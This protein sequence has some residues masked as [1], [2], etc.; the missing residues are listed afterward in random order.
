MY[1]IAATLID[2]VLVSTV[3]KKPGQWLKP[4][5][6]SPQVIEKECCKLLTYV[7]LLGSYLPS[8]HHPVTLP[9]LDSLPQSLKCL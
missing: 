1:K 4:H 5:H 6:T 9:I 3:F 7:L 8:N 2:G